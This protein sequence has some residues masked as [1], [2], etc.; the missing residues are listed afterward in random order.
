MSD[1]VTTEDPFQAYERVQVQRRRVATIT[2]ENIH[3]IARMAKARV[4]YSG[5]DPVIVTDLNGGKEMRWKVGWEVSITG[6]K[7]M[8]QNGF[9]RDDD[10]RRVDE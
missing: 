3:V 4:D 5:E 6:Y 10:W 1:Q 2:E 7:L 9:N 8:N